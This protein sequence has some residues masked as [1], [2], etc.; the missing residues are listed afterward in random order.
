MVANLH[1]TERPTKTQ[2]IFNQG[3]QT[4]F[5][6]SYQSLFTRHIGTVLITQLE[7]DTHTIKSEH[8]SLS[9]LSHH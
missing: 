1:K 3:A 4:G 6:V 7:K 5:A 2:M 9:A 8:A